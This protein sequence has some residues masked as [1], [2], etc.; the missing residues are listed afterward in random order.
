MGANCWLPHYDHSL[1]A[2]RSPLNA[3]FC[4][5]GVPGDGVI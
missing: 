5:S 4:I 1:R 2:F 3:E